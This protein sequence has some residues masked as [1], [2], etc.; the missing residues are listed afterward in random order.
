MVATLS[1]VGLGVSRT[2]R[3]QDP[4]SKVGD[5]GLIACDRCQVMNLGGR[6]HQPID[7]GDRTDPAHPPP[8]ISD[9]IVDPGDATIEG[10]RHLD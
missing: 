2:I 5:I 9:G 3:I 6:R 7:D 8:G 1:R 4:G 10:G